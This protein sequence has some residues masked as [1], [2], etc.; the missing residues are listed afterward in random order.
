MKLSY[1]KNKLDRKIHAKPRCLT[2]WLLMA[3]TLTV[4]S[5]EDFP[6]CGEEIFPLLI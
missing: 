2:F 5:L 6:E 3:R 4:G 1:I